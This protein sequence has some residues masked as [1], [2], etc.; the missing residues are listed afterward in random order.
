MVSLVRAGPWLLCG[1]LSACAPRSPEPQEYQLTGQVLAV[2]P[3]TL[4]LVIKHQDIPNFMPGMTMPFK[5]RDRGLFERTVAG[6]LVT[7]TLVVE[8]T[9][10]W[11]A[12]VHTTGT[13]PL[14]SDMPPMAMAVTILAPG[15]MAPDTSLTDQHG[16]AMTLADWREHAVAVTF[17]YTRCPLPQF[18]PMLDR[19]FAEV[20]RLAGAATD[21]AGRFRLLSVSFDPDIDTP[22]V[23]RAHAAKLGADPAVWSFATGPRERVDRFAAHFGLNVIREPDRTITHN[24]RTAVLAPGGRVVVIHDGAEWTASSLVDELRRALRAAPRSS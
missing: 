9:D 3:D 15:D 19:R 5:V 23:L 16:R 2:R 7:A 13:A 8:D 22:A 6:D 11:I 14:P 21:L 20:Q 17:V 10:A 24:M 4:E 18:C 1:L 12:A